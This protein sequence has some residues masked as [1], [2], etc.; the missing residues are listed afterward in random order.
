[1]PIRDNGA[2]PTLR[3]R[4]ET[5]RAFLILRYAHASAKA[6]LDAFNR[7]RQHRG[8]VAGATRDVE[9][10]LLRG[11]VVMA[12]AGLDSMLKQLIRDCLQTLAACDEGVREGLEKFVARQLRSEAGESQSAGASRFLARVLTAADTRDQVI[13]EYVQFLTGASLQSAD[14][15]MRAAGALGLKPVALGIDPDVLRPIFGVR[16]KIIHELDIDFEAARRNRAHRTIGTMTEH[17]NT[18]L[19]T[20]ESILVAAGEKLEA[21]Q[22]QP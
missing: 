18:L 14:E 21:L 20:A 10:D 22:A 13:E 15:V 2:P 5:R 7:V 16:N 11:M 9:Q 12:G 8:A 3:N 6:F 19:Q 4:K 17:A 1:M